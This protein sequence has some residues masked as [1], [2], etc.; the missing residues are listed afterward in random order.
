MD[1]LAT[2]LRRRVLFTLLYFSEGAPIGF[3]WL[4]MP[5]LFR[6]ADVRIDRI[7]V[8]TA[9]LVLPWTFKFVWAPLVDAVQTPQWTLRNWIIA[10]QCVMGLTLIP[11]AVLDLHQ[12]FLLVG[13]VLLAHAFAAAT[14]DVAIDGLCVRV[15]AEAERGRLNG[16][17]QA[18]MQVGRA[19]FGGGALIAAGR[20]GL[21]GV[22]LMLAAVTTG[23]AIALAGSKIPGEQGG[24]I[25]A[26]I[27]S[28]LIRQRMWH[29]VREMSLLVR[30]PATWAA[31]A[32]ALTAGAAFEAL[33]AVQG[34]LLLDQGFRQDEIGQLMAVPI[35][36]CT[37]VGAL[38][39]GY[40]ADRYGHRR[41]V[42]VGL[43]WLVC[44]VGA[45]GLLERSPSEP[46][47]PASLPML[48]M[49]TS[50]GIGLFTSS[51]YAMF[52]DVV[53]RRVAGT[54]LSALM[55]ATNGCE[56]WS[57]LAVG[58]LTR[59]IGLGTALLLMCVVSL[60]S[61]PL[62]WLVRKPQSWDHDTSPHCGGEASVGNGGDQPRR[63][64]SGR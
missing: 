47:R 11:L 32:F 28:G 24:S 7:T 25:Q 46:S 16:W 43:L 8:L 61:L 50:L 34:P 31:V 26:V 9:A 64:E 45:T 59:Q 48:L 19:L 22:V 44:N 53:D 4:A 14:Q 63:S 33:G 49:A 13:A 55:G 23:T 5:T 3:I 35:V 10:A 42:L 37:I 52:M 51:S 60:L 17:M 62:L 54:H 39:G 56:S 15:T 58:Q 57:G 21:V 1:L 18:G 2:P 30:R 27:Q 41:I 12:D 36:V 40:L 29:V 6:Q 20:F 38:A